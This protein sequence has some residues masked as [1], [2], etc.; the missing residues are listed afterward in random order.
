MAT[1]T[2]LTFILPYIILRNVSVHTYV[3]IFACSFI[4]EQWSL[5]V[6]FRIV[7]SKQDKKLEIG[8]Q[9]V[10][11]EPNAQWL[12]LVNYLSAWITFMPLYYCKLALS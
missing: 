7:L 8:I 12:K 11:N 5:G 2:Q 6:K 3:C 1:L 9:D 10:S 4:S